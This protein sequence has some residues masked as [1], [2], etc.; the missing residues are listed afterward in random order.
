LLT[1]HLRQLVEHA[2]EGNKLDSHYDILDHIRQQLYAEADQRIKRHQNLRPP[3]SAMSQMQ[4]DTPTVIPTPGA[5][6]SSPESRQT[7]LS[8]VAIAPAL[9]EGL[10]IPGPHEDA[11]RNYVT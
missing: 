4:A 5:I 10:D 9:L 11:I 3:T 1:I 6:Q 2:K 8:T 7:G